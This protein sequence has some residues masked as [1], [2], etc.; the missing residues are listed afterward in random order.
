MQNYS[1]SKRLSL[2][3]LGMLLLAELALAGAG[4]LFQAA[5]L[6]IWAVTGLFVALLSTLVFNRLFLGH[7]RHLGEL[8]AVV[9]ALSRGDLTVKIPWVTPMQARNDSELTTKT[10]LLAQ[11]F[12]A[13]FT[14]KFSLHP[15]TQVVVGK[16]RVPALRTGQT[17]LNLETTIVDRFTT[18]SGGVATIFAMRGDDLVR[19]TTSLKKSDGSRVVGTMLDNTLPVYQKLLKGESFVGAAQLFGKTFMTR[20]D[21][22]LSEHGD[23]IGALFVGLEMAQQRI[24]EDEILA[25]ARG[26]NA[27]TAGFGGFVTGLARAAESVAS[28]ATELAV[29]TERVAVSSRQQSEAAATTAAAVEQVTVS[30]GHVADHASATEATSIA[31]CDLSDGGE[32]I[33]GEASGEI[34]R[35]ADSVNA[36]SQVV[37]SLGE[38]STEISGIVQ[39]IRKIADQ[40]NLLALNAAIEAARAGEQ[41]RGFAVVADEVRKLAEN[42]GEATQKISGMIDSIRHEIED[43]VVNMDD[44]RTQ[45]QSGVALAEQARGSLGEISRET[46]HTLEMIREIS[47]ATKE[48]SVAS[49]EIARNVETIAQ[50]T[51]EN[52]SVIVQLSDAATHLEQMSSNLQNMANRFRL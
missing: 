46:H 23:T 35:V 27:V 18:S 40:T 42:T 50:M 10:D 44:S 37:S 43:A 45:V 48:Q 8:V 20:Y 47:A 5:S 3:F 15:E 9:S 32:R 7:I 19:I 41:G 14:E 28:A 12:A 49:N 22:L 4:W 36:L 17:T 30:I 21:P 25:L 6:T 52:S 34:A 16:L 33:V 38:R 11:E 39:V 1:I 24:T 51:D 2:A 31:T 29:N 26:I 13:N